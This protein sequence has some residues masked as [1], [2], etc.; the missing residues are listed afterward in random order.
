MGVPPAGFGVP[1]KQP[2]AIARDSRADLGVPPKS[3][4]LEDLRSRDQV[5]VLAPGL[6][7]WRIFRDLCR[8]ANARGNLVP[9]A[10]HAAL[11]IEL[12]CEWLTL[13]RGYGRFPGLA[14]RHPLD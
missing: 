12:G 10:Y 1:P 4:F 3:E 13:D 6:E 8:R 7:H 11:A 2:S 9:D 14:W 5:H